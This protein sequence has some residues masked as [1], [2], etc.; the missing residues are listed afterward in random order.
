MK[1]KIEE[2]PGKYKKETAATDPYTIVRWNLENFS[3]ENDILIQFDKENFVTEKEQIS[4]ENYAQLPDNKKIVSLY[5]TF[6]AL[7][8]M[9]DKDL[10][11]FYSPRKRKSWDNINIDKTEFNRAG[12]PAL[13]WLAVACG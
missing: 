3:P 5:F 4:Y 7:I 1:I 2:F 8:M 12:K 6:I 13:A 10:Y 9:Q 11:S